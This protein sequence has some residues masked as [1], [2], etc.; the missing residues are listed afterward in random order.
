MGTLMF[1][2]VL[3]V[4]GSFAPAAPAHIVDVPLSQPFDLKVGEQVTI[5]GESV[6]IG[7][8]EILNDSRCPRDVQCVWAGA[9][10]ITVW[11]EKK[12]R[13]RETLTLRVPNAD[14]PVTYEQYS[15]SLKD[16]KPYPES[17]RRPQ[18]DEYVATL[19]VARI[20]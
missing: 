18:R 7:F 8:A 11:V 19:V 10:T 9:A 20:E 13:A 5:A 17:N 2:L 3:L 12:P 4:A 15:V 1:V 6:D 14:E 16:V